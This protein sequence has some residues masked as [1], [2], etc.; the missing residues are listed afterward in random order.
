MN[1]PEEISITASQF[2]SLMQTLI[3]IASVELYQL[4]F[5]LILLGLL[6]VVIIA[7]SAPDETNQPT[8]N[9]AKET[10]YDTNADSG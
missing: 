9:H 10:D 5:T 8:D 6:V 2:D 1:S 3:G 4:V 7:T